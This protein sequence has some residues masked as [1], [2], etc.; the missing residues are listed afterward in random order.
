MS[1]PSHSRTYRNSQGADIRRQGMRSGGYESYNDGSEMSKELDQT[2]Q[3]TNDETSSRQQ[4]NVGFT[5]FRP[6]ER[7]R[8]QM[9]QVAKKEMEEADARR[10]A[11]RLQ[12]VHERPS[13][14]GGA[15]NYSTAVMQKQKAVKAASSGLEMQK[16]R[17]KWQ[18][19]KREAEERE[20]RERKAKAREQAERNELR[21]AIRTQEAAE[22]HKEAHRLKN[23]DFLDSLER[24]G[25]YNG[26]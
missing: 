6:D 23:Q 11:R 3:Q 26:Y 18:R 20:N 24:R 14:V 17:E 21:R 10:E 19:E 16:K 2:G 9:E 13:R 5:M 22:R 1:Y 8:A 12:Y 7:K 4:R 25:R 15:G